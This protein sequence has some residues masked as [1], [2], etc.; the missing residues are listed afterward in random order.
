MTLNLLSAR[1]GSMVKKSFNNALL[2]L[3]ETILAGEDTA[4][5]ILHRYFRAYPALGKRDRQ[6]LRETLFTWLRLKEPLVSYLHKKGQPSLLQELQL[7]QQIV[8]HPLE[9]QD[10]FSY[11]QESTN[12]SVA[13]ALPFWIIKDLSQHYLEQEIIALGKSFITQAPLDI[14]TNLLKTSRKA[15]AKMLAEEG[16]AHQLCTLSPWGITLLD[17]PA[18]R[19]H[20]FYQKGFFELQ[21]QGSQYIAYLSGAKQNQT[22]ID[23]CAGTGGK[24][25]ALAMMMRNSGSLYAC[26]V[27]TKRLQQLKLRMQKAG[28]NN[29]YPLHINDEEDAKLLTLR[30]KADV[31]LVDAPCSGLGTL[32]RQPDLK[33]RNHPQGIDALQ[34]KQQRILSAASQLCALGATLLY[35]TCS[36]MWQE[37]EAVIAHFLRE[38]THFSLKKEAR[39]S[40]KRTIG[41]NSP[42]GIRLAP[43]QSDGFFIAL[44]ENTG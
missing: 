21:D 22:V 27:K 11:W 34:Q 18:I 13:A 39:N 19:L 8:H 31:V 12:L 15:L 20:P 4:E 3:G 5:R 23:F 35:A 14:R 43:P 1:F 25:L 33:Y 29:V 36:F 24:T 38:N 10:F 16:M 30:G 2:E 40:I 44:L 6:N 26:D 42:Y 9:E 37:N 7:A 28:V 17:H 32:R 41:L